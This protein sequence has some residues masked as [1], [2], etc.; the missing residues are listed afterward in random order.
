M[1]ISHLMKGSRALAES[2]AAAARDRSLLDDLRRAGQRA[3]VGID[4]E[5]IARDGD[6]YRAGQAE[7]V[8]AIATALEERSLPRESTELLLKA[9]RARV[10]GAV[11][12][13]PGLNQR[14]LAATLELATS[15]LNEYLGE[16]GTHGFIEP[17]APLEG[18]GVAYQVTPW[19]LQAMSFLQAHH[20]GITAARTTAVAAAAAGKPA[21]GKGAAGRA[22]VAKVSGGAGGKAPAISRVSSSRAFVPPRPKNGGKRED[23]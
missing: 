20:P 18:R 16:L 7:L 11:S 15:N 5:A 8:L 10:L 12:L 23:R 14:Q 9:N 1:T 13:H 2:V 19:G 21:G 6:D 22:V 3:L 4:P 17:T